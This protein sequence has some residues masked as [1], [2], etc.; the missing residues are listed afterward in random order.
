LSLSTGTAV[1]AQTA[2]AA[3]PALV[4][5]LIP[6]KTVWITDTTGQEEKMRVV[7]LSGGIVTATAGE[8]LRRLPTNE[9]LRVRARRSDSVINGALIGAGA[10]VASG[11]FLCTLTEPWEFCRADEG[12]MIR[13]SAIGVGIGIGVDA[14]IRGRETIYE[15][16][17]RARRFYAAPLVANRARGLQVTVGF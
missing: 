10:G 17:P 4:S 14:L 1:L 11:L 3:E 12:S 8:I 7:G 2:T 16:A 5:T 13:I 6:G 9:V 15:R